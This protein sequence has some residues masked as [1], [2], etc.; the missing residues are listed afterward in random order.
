MIDNMNMKSDLKFVKIAL[1][2]DKFKKFE[3]P[4]KGSYVIVNIPSYTLR[5]YTPD[6][7]AVESKVAV[8]K[9]KTKT[10][11]MESEISDIIVMPLWY[12]PPSI[13]KLPG[14]IDRHRGNRNFIVRGR[15]VIQKS[16]PGNALGEMKFNFKSSEDVY[17]HDTNEKWVF[18]SAY[19]AVSHG[20]VRVQN[21]KKLASFITSVSPVMEK[22]YIRMVDKMKI[23]S[24]KK[25]TSYTYKYIVKDS[26]L[27]KTDTIPG[28]VNRKVHRELQ[29]VKKVPIYIKY[30][31]CAVRKGI[32][33][34]YN[35]VYGYDKVLQEKYFS[36]NF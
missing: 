21:Y 22:D 15:S 30:M 26:V 31:T 33:V 17:L 20:C 16:G 4:H 35:D 14:Y 8:G 29:V 2:M 5:A 10:P 11:I 7:V 23:D 36:N 12:V 9:T 3:I 28:M 34:L 13:L 18:G 25:D 6:S 19:R 24:V 1:T 32:F 27:Y